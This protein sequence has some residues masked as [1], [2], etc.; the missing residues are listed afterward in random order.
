VAAAAGL[1]DVAA[2]RRAKQVL[3]AVAA[4]RP[5]DGDGP[6][7]LR[8]D[9]VRYRLVAA[10]ADEAIGTPSSLRRA[11]A[12]IDH[13]R[14]LSPRDPVARGEQA[15]LLLALADLTGARV[16]LV[17]ARQALQRLVAGDP[18]DAEALLRLGVVQLRLGDLA[19]AE[20]AWHAAE[21]LAPRSAA[22]ST[23]LAAAYL[24]AG[25]RGDARAAA[26]RALARDPASA[27]ARSVLEATTP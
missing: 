19:A 17:A 18:L 23:D 14:R 12:E 11:L 6:A 13:A 16:D 7:R 26:E 5:S 2:D 24:A 22:A 9:A 20:T 27:A 25:R 4:D 8:P 15:R 3:D 1:L 10:L 21:D